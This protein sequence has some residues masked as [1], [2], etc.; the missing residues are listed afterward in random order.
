MPK[1][2]I[3]KEMVVAAAFE[4]ARKE[5]IEKATVKAISEKLGCSVQPIYS[6]CRNMDGLRQEVAEKA[7]GFVREYAAKHID[8]NDLFRSTG[9]AYVQ[10]A[11]EEPHLFRLY[12][13]QER[14]GVT[15]LEDIYR[16]ETNPAVAHKI[17]ADLKIPVPAAKQ[18]H[19]NM[20]IYTIGIGTIFSVTSSSISEE[21]IYE[22]QEQAY[23]A[24]LKNAKES[25]GNESGDFGSI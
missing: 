11:K 5:G 20:L 25:Q 7:R 19:L 1:Q 15:S 21:E 13:F 10:I 2:R 17:A 6:Y 24:F 22:Q 9:H 18:L 8:P 16:T 3:T 14:K 23:E 4:I 12:L